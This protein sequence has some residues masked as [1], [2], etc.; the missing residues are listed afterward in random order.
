[1]AKSSTEAEY[2]ALS[3]ATSEV[4]W[5][6]RLAAELQLEQSSPT[7]IHCDNISAIAIAKNL[8]FHTRTKHIEIDYQFI[9]Q[10]SVRQRL[11]S[12]HTLSRSDS[13][14][15]NQTVFLFLF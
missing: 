13:R 7:I 8:V 14:H 15:F 9:R 12:T 3:A 1:M 6:R 11:R 4:I 5:L 2:R 10:H